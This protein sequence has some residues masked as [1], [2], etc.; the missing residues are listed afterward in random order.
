MHNNIAEQQQQY[1]TGKQC[2][3]ICTM[4]GWMTTTHPPPNSADASTAHAVDHSLQHGIWNLLTVSVCMAK[5][6][7]AIYV[8][9]VMLAMMNQLT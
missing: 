1:E 5:S 4:D 7:G 6:L 2:V 3:S 8:M 9:A